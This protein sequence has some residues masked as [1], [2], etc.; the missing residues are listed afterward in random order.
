MFDKE[1]CERFIDSINEGSVQID[2]HELE[3]LGFRLSKDGLRRTWLT[4]TE[5]YAMVFHVTKRIIRDRTEWSDFTAAAGLQGTNYLNT[6]SIP[7]VSTVSHSLETKKKAS[8]GYLTPWYFAQVNWFNTSG[9]I[10]AMNV[11][12]IVIDVWQ[13]ETES[14]L[15]HTEKTADRFLFAELFPIDQLITPAAE[16]FIF[17]KFLNLRYQEALENGQEEILKQCGE[18]ARQRT[19]ELFENLSQP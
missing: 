7:G 9:H 10:H 4:G 16:Y 2:A 5:V 17:G 18:I 3:T 15:S 1:A 19:I 13:Y 11:L 8:A 14:F 12:N 6:A